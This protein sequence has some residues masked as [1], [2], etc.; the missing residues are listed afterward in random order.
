MKGSQTLMPENG[1]G[2]REGSLSN[3]VL[4]P[5]RRVLPPSGWSLLP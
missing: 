3:G 2:G 5:S 4:Q 1:G